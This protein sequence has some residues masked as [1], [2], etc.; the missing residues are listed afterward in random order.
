MA[1]FII[2]RLL[3]LIP[4]L[5][6]VSILVF[7]LL[8]VAPGDAA[9]LRLAQLGID[10]TPQA[11]AD[12][13]AAL[14]LDRP[15]PLQ[16]LAWLGDALRGDFG[17]SVA[18]GRPAL[19]EF[20]VRF[21]ATLALALPA[22]ALT[23]AIAFPAGVGAAMYRG[24]LFDG[25]TRLASIA[26]LSIPGFCLGLLLIL[27]F[28]VRLGWLPSFGAGGVAHLILPC[29][30]LAL[31]FAASYTRFVRATMLEELSRDYVRA[32]RARG[33][34]KGRI[35]WGEALKNAASPII[36]SLS[37]Q[38]ALLLG[39]SAVVEK[40]F[41][42]PGVGKFLIDAILARDYPVVQC[43]VL[44]FAV[45]FVGL[46]LV[47]D[48]LCLL[49]DPRLHRANAMALAHGNSDELPGRADTSGEGGP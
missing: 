3:W 11:L 35:V 43:C 8:R 27:L 45:F 5:L 40:V 47:A 32:A 25:A 33:L 26:L 37:M 24:G 16:Y 34:A 29:A 48:L 31:G 23:A 41:S 7:L 21:P 6:G 15:L 14:G 38:L 44:I 36:T 2:R 20:A 39:G 4:V 42:W 30:T 17:D 13:R 10:P 49:V 12:M 9:Q 18:T 46:N 28:S 22:I 19:A 1:R